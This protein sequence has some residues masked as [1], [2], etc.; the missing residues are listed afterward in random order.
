[1]IKKL[2]HTLFL[3]ERPSIGL[4]FFRIAAAI[5]VGCHVLPTFFALKENYLAG[6]FKVLNLNFFTQGFLNWVQGSPDSL[7]VAVVVVFCLAWFCFLIGL[8][9][10][11]SCIVMTLGCYYFYALNDFA[12]G[13][14]SWDILLV[15]LFL[16]CLT[17]YLGDS[18]SVDS[19]LRSDQTSYRRTRPYF[20]QRLLQIQIAL[21]YF[22]TGLYK[23]SSQGNWLTANPVYDLLLM[24]D[25]GVTKYFLLRDFFIAHPGWCYVLGVLIVTIELLMPILLFCPAT[26]YSA[27]YLGFVFHITLILTLDVPAI[28]FFLFPAQLLLFIPPEKVIAW[29]ENQRKIFQSAPPVKVVFDGD[30]GFCTASVG[31]LKTMD[32]FGRLTFVN[33]QTVSD[34]STVHADLTK[35]KAHS[36]LHLVDANGDLYPGFF[37]FRRMSWLLP[38]LYPAIALLYFPGANIVGPWVYALIAKNRYLFHFNK[39]CGNNSCLR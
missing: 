29:I 28:F 16:L 35:D 24:P 17:P 30:C 18:F 14:L 31:M 19:L 32:L 15:T 36:Q 23:I 7:V 21:T 3:R 5:T 38:M 13:T 12:V 9:T 10:Q 34:L 20:L 27:I 33:Y 6:A 11:V 37:A 22:Y 26:R 4:A 8:W 1:M 2:W 39:K 25:S